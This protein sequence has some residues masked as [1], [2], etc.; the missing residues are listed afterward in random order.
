MASNEPAER[1]EEASVVWRESAKSAIK[2]AGA[3]ADLGVAKQHAGR[4]LEPFSHI[5]VV[6]TA[7]EFDNFFWLRKHPDAQPEIQELAEKMYEARKNA[8]T[9]HLTV[10]EWH[11]P[12]FG[13]GYWTPLVPSKYTLE[14]AL[15]ISASCCAQVSYRKADDS[16]EKAR[17][18]FKR[19]VESKP[20][21]ASPFEHQAK[22]MSLR[23]M[24]SNEEGVTHTDVRGHRWSGNFREWIQHRQLIPDNACWDY[25]VDG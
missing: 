17:D 24:Q 2:S 20:V 4:I 19:L 18:I 3:L 16:L 14:D 10:S 8:I 11:V 9:N 12:Y 6:L 1:Q 21:H 15:A 22:P 13:D 23:A 7:T 25:R 5:K